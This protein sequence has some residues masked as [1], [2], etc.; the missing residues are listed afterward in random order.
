MAAQ[1]GLWLYEIGSLNVKN[2]F[3]KDYKPVVYAVNNYNAAKGNGC[4]V[5]DWWNTLVLIGH[6]GVSSNLNELSY[7]FVKY[8]LFKKIA[9][10]PS[11]HLHFQ[12]KFK[13]LA[14]KFTSGWSMLG[15]VNKHFYFQKFVDNTEQY[16]ASTPQANFP[17][18][19]LNFHWWWR[20]WNRIQ[21]TF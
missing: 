11:H 8:K 14:G 13:L 7:L 12:W 5:I 19:N 9:W 20:W 3:H 4:P 17:S 18:H 1:L 10:I 15:D 6:N 21:A 2:W 16:F